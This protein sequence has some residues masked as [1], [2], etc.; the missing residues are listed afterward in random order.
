MERSDFMPL[1]R[2]GSTFS[3]PIYRSKKTSYS[4]PAKRTSFFSFG[5]SASVTI[6]A[7]LTLPLFFMAVMTLFYMLEVMSIRTAIRCGMQYAAKAAAENAYIVPIRP[8]ATLQSDIV[9]AIGEERL[10]RS[11]IV[12]GASGIR[13]DESRMSAITGIL[14]LKVTY[15]VKLPL[16][17]FAVP[18]TSMEESMRMKGWTGYVRTGDIGEQEETVY[19]TEN[20]IVYHRDYHCNYLDLSIRAVSSA[21]VSSMR[22]EDGGRYYPCEYCTSGGWSENGNFSGM[23]Y[24]TD[25]GD[26][27]HSSVGCSRLKRTIYAVP[28]SEAVGKG[29]CSKCCR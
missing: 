13:C 10:E 2:Q 26:H 16:P 1:L 25:Y 5:I 4:T 20:G 12:G 7:A 27:Y 29:A 23:V 6:E 22:N 8:T 17:V 19:I 11:I 9:Q 3:K 15:Q 28:V 24:V 18:P 14:N 21:A